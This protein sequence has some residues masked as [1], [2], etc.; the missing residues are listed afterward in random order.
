M[1]AKGGKRARK[2]P[3]AQA[4][5]GTQTPKQP[6]R[7]SSPCSTSAPP[8]ASQQRGGARHLRRGGRSGARARRVCGGRSRRRAR[9]DRRAAHRQ[10]G[11]PGHVLCTGGGARVLHLQEVGRRVEHDR[12]VRG[13]FAMCWPYPPRSRPPRIALLR[14]PLSPS[15]SNPRPSPLSCCRLHQRCGSTR[16][17]RARANA[18]APRGATLR[19]EAARRGEAARR[20]RRRRRR[21]GATVSSNLSLEGSAFRPLLPCFRTCALEPPLACTGPPTAPPAR[22]LLCAQAL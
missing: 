5:P 16:R 8:I 6:R 20:W 19:R 7:R 4:D 10:V 13:R 17:R 1:V 14:R 15:P 12:G 18:T 22:H 9:P 11:A 21:S 2:A 3:Q